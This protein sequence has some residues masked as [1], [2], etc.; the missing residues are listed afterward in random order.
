MQ[1]L[2]A[3]YRT[4]QR[5]DHQVVSEKLHQQATPPTTLLCRVYGISVNT[6]ALVLPGIAY[7]HACM[8]STF[9]GRS[10][11]VSQRYMYLYTFR[12]ILQAWDAVVYKHKPQNAVSNGVLHAELQL[13]EQVGDP[14]VGGGPRDLCDVTCR[15]ENRILLVDFVAWT[16]ESTVCWTRFLLP[17]AS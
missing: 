1:Q 6:T 7:I 13:P 11:R 15:I 5:L 16:I 12:T 9:P 14:V 4:T 10:A 2:Q 3:R 8:H 17:D